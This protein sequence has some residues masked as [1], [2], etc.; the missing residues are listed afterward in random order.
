MGIYYLAGLIVG[1]LVWHVIL[2]RREGKTW[3]EILTFKGW[4]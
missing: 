1:L 2:S 4:F 3:K